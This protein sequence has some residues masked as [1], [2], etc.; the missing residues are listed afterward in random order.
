MKNL[1]TL[2]PETLEELPSRDLRN[3]LRCPRNRHSKPSRQFRWGSKYPSNKVQRFL[4]SN[5]GNLW[6]DVF[7]KYCHLDWIPADLRNLE[8]IKWHVIIDTF[9]KDGKVVY[10]P[11][12]RF[13]E[14][15]IENAAGRTEAFYVDPRTK[16]LSVV[17]F[18]EKKAKE[19]KAQESSKNKTMQIIG[20][21]HQFLKLKGLWH[22]V[23]AEPTRPDHGLICIDRL[24]YKEANV[25][26]V[27]RW[28]KGALMKDI[29]PADG[30]KYKI[31]NGKL[32]IPAQAPITHWKR[33][34]GPSDR[35]I[36]ESDEQP[37]WMR[38]NDIDS[39][40]FK[41]TLQRQLSSKELKQHG[42]KN[43][44]LL[45]TKYC[46]KCGGIVGKDCRFHYCAICDKPKDDCKCYGK[47]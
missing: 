36:P 30:V 7:S 23:R 3:A 43:D 14:E 32:Y 12:Y 10:I 26:P 29:A 18:G 15:P 8:H 44:P 1:L 11:K 28:F 34:L 37:R 27:K 46:K 16:R 41:V 22:E 21:Y 40:S 13:A 33:P 47:W 17:S 2:R 31:H 39:Y 20:P 9:L 4:R 35:I 5:V 24:H 25:K 19:K 45:P 38:Y 42:L 6:N